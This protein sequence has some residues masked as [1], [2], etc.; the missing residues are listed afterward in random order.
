MSTEQMIPWFLTIFF[1]LC[2]LYFSI[3]ANKRAEHSEVEKD[4][5]SMAMVMAKLDFISESLTEIKA[6]NK[7][8]RSE[9]NEF[10]ERLAQNEA[11]IKSFHKRLDEVTE[12]HIIS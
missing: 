12:H 7:A 11:A 1:G 8:M 5:T 3:K 9:M 10:R 6:D 4:S 2:T